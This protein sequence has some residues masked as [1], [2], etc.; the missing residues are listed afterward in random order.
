MKT[1]VPNSPFVFETSEPEVKSE[2]APARRF[3][4]DEARFFADLARGDASVPAF[5]SAPRAEYLDAIEMLNTLT[6]KR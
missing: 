5:L 6:E 4:L 1:P 2:P 3:V